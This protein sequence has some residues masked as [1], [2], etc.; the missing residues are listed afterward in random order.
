MRASTSFRE[1]STPTDC[2]PFADPSMVI[3]LY[4]AATGPCLAASDTA[5]ADT[6]SEMPTSRK[7]DKE[8]DQ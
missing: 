2:R 3:D 7:H 8:T 4:I 5:W 1:R 6:D